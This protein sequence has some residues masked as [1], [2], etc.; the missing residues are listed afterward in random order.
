MIEK[1]ISPASACYPGTPIQAAIRLI[2]ENQPK[3]I[4]FN[5]W[6]LTHIQICPQH[7]GVVSEFA[8]NSL[9]E[10]FPNTQFRLHANVRINVEHRPF[11]AGFSLEENMEY[12]SQL[13]KI[14]IKIGAKH[15]SY[16]AP[17]RNNLGW[18]DIAKNVLEL[19][20]FLQTPVSLEGLYPRQK[21]NDDL[22]KDSV[23]AYE[24]ILQMDLLY[25]LDLSHLNIVYEQENEN[26]KE[27]LIQLTQEMLG[28][29]NCKEVHISAND[30]KHDSHKAISEDF[31]WAKLL[32]EAQL[33]N[34]C[35]IFCESGQK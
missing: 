16:H 2:S 21:L 19:Q 9:M 31:W 10:K 12:I 17:M 33:P 24:T 32:N 27:R 20:D 4:C 6:D 1:N 5:N 34:D 13:K 25:A 3:D 7:I 11:D 26:G 29:K 15:Y 18:K 28:H 8:I 35:V 22:W 30:G 23:A 14:H